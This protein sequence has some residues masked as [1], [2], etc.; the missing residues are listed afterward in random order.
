MALWLFGLF[1]LFCSESITCQHSY[2]D[3]E[4]LSQV[5][6][7]DGY[8]LGLSADTEAQWQLFKLGSKDKSGK[9]IIQDSED[10]E[11]DVEGS[12]YDTSSGDEVVKKK[13]KRI[14]KENAKSSNT[15]PKRKKTIELSGVIMP[16][17]GDKNVTVEAFGKL[18]ATQQ[19]NL[20]DGVNN[21]TRKV[22]ILIVVSFTSSQFNHFLFPP[23]N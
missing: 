11:S 19:D 2:G 12:T 18:S 22:T 6:L 17:P 9:E 23:A 1:A 3:E 20:A 21:K 10:E 5:E 8:L 14:R 15:K 16:K 4:E 7:R 13:P